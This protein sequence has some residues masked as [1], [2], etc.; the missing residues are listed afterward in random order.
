LVF[1]LFLKKLLSQN[2]YWMYFLG[3]GAFEE[4][5]VAL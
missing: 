1:K 3:G 5:L 4:E 2:Y